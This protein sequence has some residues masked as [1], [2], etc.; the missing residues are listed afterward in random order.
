[1]AK[2]LEVLPEESSS[3]EQ[4][5]EQVQN[6]DENNVF[7]NER[8][9]SENNT[10]E[11]A[12]ERDA[13]ASQLKEKSKVISDLKVKEEKD[14]DKMIEMEEKDIDKMNEI[15]YTRNQ[16]IQTIHMLTPNAR[17]KMV[18][19]PLH[20]PSFRFEHEL[21]MEMHE[22]YEYVKSLEKEV[23]ELESEKADFSNIYDLLLEECVSK[24]VT[25]SYLHSLS[26]LN[27][28]AE[29]QCL[30]LHKVKECE[31]GIEHQTSTPQ[32]PEQNGRLSKDEPHSFEAAR[33]ML[34]ASKHFINILG[35]KENIDTGQDGKK[36]VPDQEYI[37]LLLLASD[38]SLS[39]S[40]KDFL[41]AGFKPSGE[42]E[43]MDSEHPE[44]KDSEMPNIEEPR[45]HQDQDVNVNSTNNINTVCPTVNVVDIENNVVDENIVYG[46]IDD[47]SM[48]NLEEIV[49]SDDDEE[50]GAEAD[51]N[52]LATTV[53]VSPIPTIRVHKDHPLEQIIGDIHSAP[54]TRRMTK[55][56]TEHGMFSS[57]QQRINHK[58]FQN[59]LF[60][61]FLSQVEPK[62]V[63][64]ALTDPS[65]IE[66]MQDELLQFKLQ[67]VW[68]LVDLPYGK[69]AIGTK[70]VYRNKKD[71]RGIVVRNKARLVAQGYTQEEGIDYDEVFAP[72][73]RIEA[74]R[75][76]L[77]Y[78]SFMNF[79][80]YQMDVK[81]AFLYGTIEEE[82]YVCQPPGFEDPEFPNR[83]YKVEKALYGLHQAPKAWYE[84]LSTYLL[85]NGFLRGR[86]D[87]TDLEMMP[88][89]FQMRILMGELT[90][91]IGLQVTQKYDGECHQSRQDSQFDLEAYNNSDYAGAS[92]DRKSTTGGCQFLG[93]R[94][95]SWQAE[96]NIVA[97]STT[98]A[99][100]VA[101]S[102]AVDRDSNEKK[103]IQMIKIHQQYQNVV[104]ILFSQKLDVSRFQYPACKLPTKQGI[105][106]ESV[107]T[108]EDNRRRDWMNSWNKDGNRTGKKR[109]DQKH[110]LWNMS[111]PVV[112]ES[113]IEVQPK[114]WSDAPIIEEYESDGDNEYVSVQ[115]KGPSPS[116][117]NKQVKTPGENVK[118]VSTVGG[119]WDTAVKSSAGCKWRTQ[120]YF[121]NILS[122]Y[123]GGSR[124]NI[125]FCGLKGIKRE[126]SNVRTPQQNGIAERKNMTLI[127]AVF[128]TKQGFIDIQI[129][130]KEL[131]KTCHNLH[132]EKGE[133]KYKPKCGAVE[134]TS[135]HFDLGYRLFYELSILLIRR[136][137]LPFLA[138]QQESNHNTGTI[139]F[140]DTQPL[141]EDDSEIPPLKDIHE[142]TT[143]VMSKAKRNIP[144]DFNHLGYY[145][146]FLSQQKPQN[147]SEALEE[148]SWYTKWRLQ[149]PLVKDEEASDVDVHLYRS[150]IGS[151]QE[152]PYLVIL[153]KQTIVATSTTEA[154]YVCWLQ[155]ALGCAGVSMIP[156]S[157]VRLVSDQAKEIKLL[158]AQITKLKKQ[159]KPVIKHFKAYLKT[160]SLQQRLPRKSSSKKHRMHKES[161]S[162]QGRK[163]AKGESSVQRDPLFD[164]MPE[165]N[166]D[167]MET[168]NAQSE[169]RTREMVDE[170]KEID[171]VRLSTEDVV[172]TKKE[173]VSTDFE[174][175]STDKP[176]VS[177]DGSKVSTDEQVEGT[178]EIFE[179]T[180]EQREGTEEKVESTA[181]QTEAT[182]LLNMS[183]AK[184]ASK[185]KEKGVELKD[186]EEIDRPRPT[187]T[188]SLL[189]L[190]P[191][192]K[193]D[194]KDKGKKKIEEEDESESEDDD[195]PPPPSKG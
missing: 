19:Q 166:I 66:A 127:E 146:C 78:A 188:R 63:I 149:K 194:P 135:W 8:Q 151:L 65:W 110:N 138:C 153:T 70:W 185:E 109:R 118:E 69:R 7:A 170:D 52:N 12:D 107:E 10:A 129:R 163:I 22:D 181:G 57:V 98:E 48:P 27:A 73:A 88:K 30:Y 90:F 40:S 195:I 18:D 145:A 148:E 31:E 91:S 46:C 4:P 76:F 55:N 176:I 139:Q 108:K 191:L 29:L 58:D 143:D 121:N 16:S 144:K 43:K 64:Q 119:K 45:V 81:S 56:V 67:K 158:K 136:I 150:M 14:I 160:V 97:N 36:I 79:I 156:K 72:V 124:D 133:K 154:E 15:V 165:D 32:T 53:P 93:S 1:M 86:S 130:N 182:L 83:V 113:Y 174:K 123:N 75:L 177:T 33:A 186:V 51:M 50:V 162:K 62:K 171:E 175:V 80:V 13:L 161:V 26:D 24:D 157:N 193:I 189:T 23:D 96:A 117:A 152:T 87:V 59:C 184:A 100:Y 84:T 192:P 131:K 168:E 94:L 77:A 85:E 25:C 128:S 38:P 147:N 173:G 102:I 104:D 82:V 190:K 34:S 39:K 44:N 20:K 125:E 9:H 3:T 137:K 142:D 178:E 126:Y 112:N 89:K 172:S 159:A 140:L 47:P 134:R 60:A 61:C 169:G 120:G 103:L 42:E 101:A 2:I 180:E 5:L 99:E 41:D 106:Q 105:L 111:E 35:T 164:V 71:D 17:H 115:T 92:L 28:Y 11:C 6:N 21:K 95:I 132:I 187:T 74:I 141:Q 122:K 167:H 49:Y 54:Q 37:L 114:V 155:A 179:S 68:T 183:Q 116:F